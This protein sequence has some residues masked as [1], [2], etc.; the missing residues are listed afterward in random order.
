[1]NNGLRANTV[2]P[3]CPHCKGRWPLPL[4]V[5]FIVPTAN[6]Q[7]ET[8]ITCRCGGSGILVKFQVLEARLVDITTRLTE[9]ELRV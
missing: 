5:S 2:W 9:T 8:V 7:A 4:A 6:R 3:P 1:M